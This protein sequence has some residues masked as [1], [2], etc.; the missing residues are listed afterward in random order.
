[1]VRPGDALRVLPSGRTTTVAQ[2]FVGE[3]AA[4]SGVAGQSVTLTLGSEVDVSRGDVLAA[5][6]A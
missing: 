5:A 4:A 3:G 6:G 2:V 1:M